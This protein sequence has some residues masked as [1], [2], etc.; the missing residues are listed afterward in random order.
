MDKQQQYKW[1][2]HR[3]N[4]RILTTWFV[5]AGVLSAAGAFVYQGTYDSNPQKS[6]ERYIKNEKNI[7]E[8]TLQ[9]G[10]RNLSEDGKMVRL[11]TL[12]IRPKTVKI[13]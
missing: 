1:R 12:L 2:K 9:S 6:A 8:Y 3:K 7:D 5:C 13:R 4:K 10:D 11:L